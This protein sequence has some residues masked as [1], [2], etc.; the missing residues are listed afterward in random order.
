MMPLESQKRRLFNADFCRGNTWIQL[1]PGQEYGGVLQCRHFVPCCEISAQNRP[2]C[3]S[4]VLK[5]KPTPCSLFFW[6]FRTICHKSVKQK[7]VHFLLNHLN[8]ELNPICC[9]LALLG[10]HHFLRV[11]RIRVKSLTFRLLMTYI[12]GAPILDVSRSHTTTQ[13]SR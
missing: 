10:A 8:P 6:A 5:E 4:I 2:V 3:W 1:E 11:S 9:L 13:H 7:H 12:Y